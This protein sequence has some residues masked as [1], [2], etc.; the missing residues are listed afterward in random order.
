MRWGLAA[1][2]RQTELPPERA[3]EADYMADDPTERVEMATLDAIAGGNYWRDIAQNHDASFQQKIAEF[4]EQYL[5]RLVKSFTYA[6]AYEV[7]DKYEH[8]VPKYALIYGT[9]HPDGLELMNDAMCKA[10]LQFLGDQFKKSTLFDITPEE[11]VP[12]TGQLKNDL[13]ALFGR[14]ERKT[15]KELRLHA[16]QRNFCKFQKKEINRCRC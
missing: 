11:E 15:R 7:K 3:T 16:L 14:G 1:V 6:A 8:R 12:D 5:G 13:L 4:T 10:R 9:R 2:K